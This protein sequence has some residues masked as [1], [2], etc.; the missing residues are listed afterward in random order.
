MDVE[1]EGAVGVDFGDGSAAWVIMACAGSCLALQWE[2][3]G[4][5]GWGSVLDGHRDTGHPGTGVVYCVCVP[6]I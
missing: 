1:G 2:E 6:A 3:E 5:E 4:L